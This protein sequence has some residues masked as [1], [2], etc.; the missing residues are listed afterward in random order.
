MLK[1]PPWIGLACAPVAAGLAAYL[2]GMPTLKLRGHYLAMATLGFGMI[3][4]DTFCGVL[5]TDRRYLRDNRHPALS[6][7]KLQLVDD[8]QFL[9]RGLVLRAPADLGQLQHS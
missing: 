2:I 3:V 7:G 6:L 4:Q 9:L 1:W 8:R 5:S